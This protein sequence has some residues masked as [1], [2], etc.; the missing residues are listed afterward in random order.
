M[1]NLFV[2]DDSSIQSFFKKILASRENVDFACDGKE[3]V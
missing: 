2:D 1:K 3:A